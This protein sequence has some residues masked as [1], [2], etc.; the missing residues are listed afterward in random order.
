MSLGE[1]AYRLLDS[2]G[3]P[4]ALRHMARSRLTVLCYH[5]VVRDKTGGDDYLFR[6]CTTAGEF[7]HQLRLLKRHYRPVSAK[8]LLDALRASRPLPERAVLVT[9]DDG[10]RNNLTVA[11][12][13]LEAEGVPA[14]FHL[15]TGLIGTRERLWG[16]RLDLVVMEWKDGDIPLPDGSREARPR[17]V[18]GR[19]A[20]AAR[21][22]KACKHLDDPGRLEYLGRLARAHGAPLA[23]DQERDAFMTWDD[24]RELHRRGFALGAHTVSHPIMSRLSLEQAETELRECK[25]RIE[26][27]LGT[28]CPWLAYPNGKPEDVGVAVMRSARACGFEVAFTTTPG[29]FVVGDDPLAI[30]RVGVGGRTSAAAFLGRVAGLPELVQ[31]GR[32]PGPERDYPGVEA[33]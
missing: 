3:V 11:A 20:L 30:P 25:S 4:R 5:G 15:T 29:Y 32:L 16:T 10:Y 19:R 7:R 33:R 8:D 22:R 13:E 24:A 17:D 31:R 28:E 26:R 14:L 6:N 12:P 2:I 23:G 9:F 27:E 21:L 1:F 18:A